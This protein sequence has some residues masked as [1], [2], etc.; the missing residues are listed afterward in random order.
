MHIFFCIYINRDEK[1][2]L[3]RI[4]LR[5]Q[6]TELLPGGLQFREYGNISITVP[7]SIQIY[8]IVMLMCKTVQ[9]VFFV[10]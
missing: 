6:W 2:L 1:I 3:K 9:Q 4:L 10:V 8:L 5:V 7:C